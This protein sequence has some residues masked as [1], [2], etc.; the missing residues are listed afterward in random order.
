[1]SFAFILEANAL[2]PKNLL[3]T[4]SDIMA[5]EQRGAQEA[6]EAQQVRVA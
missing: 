4:L 3:S 6:E 1:M 2:T 5:M